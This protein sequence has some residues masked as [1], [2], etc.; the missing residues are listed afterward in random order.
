MYFKIAILTLT[1]GVLLGCNGKGKQEVMPGSDDLESTA[2]CME[3]ANNH[4]V[5]EALEPNDFGDGSDGEFYLPYGEIFYLEEKEYNFT[6]VNLDEGALL[7]I[8]DELINGAGIIHIN[9]LGICNIFGDIDISGYNGGLVLNCYSG[10]TIGGALTHPDGEVTLST[11]DTSQVNRTEE[12]L[13]STLSSGSINISGGELNVRDGG[14][15][16]SGSV[17]ELPSFE[18][19][20]GLTNC[21][22]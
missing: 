5:F 2:I 20:Q 8:A 14:I 15:I 4:S 3:K 22:N 17:L 12:G 21:S 19:T 18:I 10:I 13:E 11:Y 1:F 9:S 16:V 7:G 6:N